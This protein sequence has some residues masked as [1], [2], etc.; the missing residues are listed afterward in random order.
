MA[1]RQALPEVEVLGVA[2]RTETAAMAQEMGAVHEA[3]TDVGL[4]AA[5]DLVVLACPL[6]V[7][8][9]VLE[10]CRHHL[11]RRARVTDVGSAKAEVVHFA[12]R[13]LD[14]RRN[15]FLGGHPMAGKEVT[16][17]QHAEAGLFRGR[18]WVFTPHAAGALEPFADLV[19]AVRAIGAVPINLS[20]R[21]HDRYV[22]LVSHLPFLVSAAYLLAV[23]RHEEWPDAAELASS[24]FRDI[25]RLGAGDSEMY[26][27]IAGANREEVLKAWAV[28]HEALDG[29]EAAI[30]RG[31]DDALLDLLIAARQVRTN[32]AQDHPDFD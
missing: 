13:L 25:S 28:F 16:G 20:P 2:R 5:A 19:A 12:T 24:G 3:G 21:Q 9:A 23:G 11:A 29:F 15:P 14:R 7:T 22:A 26:A 6:A 31:D 30:V 8:K 18:P 17:I 32:W 1:L 10:D 27:A 4:I